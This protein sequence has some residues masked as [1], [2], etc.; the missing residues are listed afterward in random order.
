VRDALHSALHQAGITKRVTPHSLRHAF[1]THLLEAGTDIRT[2][3][4]LLGH[5]S[6]QTTARYTYVSRRHVARTKSPLD[7]LGT[8]KGQALS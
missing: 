3:Q 2:I 4:R 8:P 6:I 7:L 1:A 5:A